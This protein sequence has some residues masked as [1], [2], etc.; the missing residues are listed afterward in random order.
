MEELISVIVPVYKV[1]KY[2]RKCVDS[3]CGQTYPQLEIILVDDGSPDGCGDICEEYAARDPRV[4]VIHKKNGGLS[5]ARNAGLDAAHGQYIGF[6]D[7]DDYIKPQMYETMLR[8][9]KDTGADLAVCSWLAV[10]EQG[11]PMEERQPP[12]PDR[13]ML[14][15]R[16]EALGQLMGKNLVSFV[17]A[18][19]RL[20]RAGV[21]QGLR[22]PVGRIH[23]DEAT[24]HHIYWRCKKVLFLRE[25]QYYYVQHPGSIMNKTFSLKRLDAA[26]AFLDRAGFALEKGMEELASFSC[27]QA[28][29]N[30]SEGYQRLDRRDPAVQAK[31]KELRHRAVQ[32]YPRIMAS[33]TSL[34]GKIV[35]TLFLIHIQCYLAARDLYL[36]LGGAAAKAEGARLGSVS[37]DSERP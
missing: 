18:V 30:I 11:D 22:F 3:I 37:Q 28:L 9:L 7:G 27:R 17:M 12:A 35:F 8:R 34:R 20:Y 23:E 14:M 2:I 29:D 10:D 15:G 24:A 5:D 1:E 16:E 21:L 6:V 33:P 26:E 31:I 32:F 4:K 36:K 19:N 25:P 13:D